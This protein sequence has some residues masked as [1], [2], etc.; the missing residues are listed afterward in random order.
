VIGNSEERDLSIR[1][2]LIVGLLAGLLAGVGVSCNSGP[3]YSQPSP[4]RPKPTDKKAGPST[5]SAPG[6]AVVTPA[7]IECAVTSLT[8]SV[9]AGLPVALKLSWRNT[10]AQA[11]VIPPAVVQPA[12]TVTVEKVPGGPARRLV[13]PAWS[14]ANLK[15]TVA[16]DKTLTR[17]ILAVM[18]RPEGKADAPLE[19]LFPEAGQF[20]LAVDGFATAA[21]LVL[22][23]EEPKG[24][25]LDACKLW[26]P[27]I[28]SALADQTSDRFRTLLLLVEPICRQYPLSPYGGYALWLKARGLTYTAGA[29]AADKE[30]AIH[31]CQELLDRHPDVMVQEA[32]LGLIVSLYQTTYRG[33]RAR[34][35]GQELATKFSDSI[36]V[37]WLHDVCGKNFEKLV[38]PPGGESAAGARVI[39]AA[40]TLEGLD[41]APKG[42]GAAFKA[43]WEAA[44][45]GD[46]PAMEGMLA[47]DFMGDWGGRSATIKNLWRERDGAQSTQ[48][49]LNIRRVSMLTSYTRPPSIPYG[50]ER[51]WYGPICLIEGALV[52]P[53][54]AGSKPAQDLSFS[55]WAFYEYPAGTWKLISEVCASERQMTAALGQKI[56]RELPQT[57]TTWHISDGQADRFPYEEI[58][59][60]VGVTGKVD[61]TKTTW[62]SQATG[63]TKETGEEVLVGGVIHME[64]AGAAPVEKRVHIMV[65]PD[66]KGGVKLIY[67]KLAPEPPPR[68]D[69]GPPPP[70]G[71]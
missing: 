65:G 14:F 42:P 1:K 71:R 66:G 5:P 25:D 41:A 20:R 70:G 55:S 23:V 44:A 16:P 27:E 59:K 52:T 8:P 32:A 67:V 7:G 62:K 12:L 53:V 63:V 4:D 15:L 33:A 35:V 60:L 17:T 11:I 39:K 61:D 48:L 19:W 18:G 54:M 21:P 36:A 38:I 45:A 46:V 13:M 9:P 47:G 69:L 57:I 3:D 37:E 24:A 40:L 68:T 49:R 28:A 30:A 29:S 64:A 58:K 43:F 26:T 22:T 6:A 50:L 10:T 2:L 31:A 51:T 56:S 34:E